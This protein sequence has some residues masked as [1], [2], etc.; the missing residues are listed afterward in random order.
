[1][2]CKFR[3]HQ[4]YSAFV[5]FPLCP[6]TSPELAMKG[7][8]TVPGSELHNSKNIQIGHEFLV[9][10]WVLWN[11]HWDTQRNY[12]GKEQTR[13]RGAASLSCIPNQ[14]GLWYPVLVCQVS[15][16]HLTSLWGH[17]STNT[18]GIILFLCYW[19]PKN[20]AASSL[21]ALLSG[22]LWRS[23]NPRKCW[24]HFCCFKFNT[25]FF[26]VSS[27]VFKLWSITGASKR[28]EQ[29]FLLLHACSGFSWDSQFSFY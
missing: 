5:F 24:I 2:E 9:I 7:P 25:I 15:T 14:T 23:S 28:Y 29:M 19:L 22:L 26:L 17:V 21:F 1:M 18:W 6:L 27:K 4:V 16:Y 12:S 20:K 10:Q 13:H 8:L 3:K 11:R